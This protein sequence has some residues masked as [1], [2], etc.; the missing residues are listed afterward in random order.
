MKSLPSKDIKWKYILIFFLSVTVFACVVMCG[1]DIAEAESEGEESILEE[2]RAN[3]DSA[4][5]ILDL[6]VFEDF[7]NS[8]DAEQQSL[9]SF[10]DLKEFI[11]DLTDGK[12]DNFFDSF[13]SVILKSL[14][15]YFVGFL[16]ALITILTVS[17]LKS[18]L[19]G[20][21]SP[22]LKTGTNE[23][24]HIVCYGVI[25]VVLASSVGSIVSTT[26]STINNMSAFA[27]GVFPVLLTLLASLGA[28]T[29]VATYQPMMAVLGGGVISIISKVILPAFVACVVFAMVG[30][31][32]KNVKLTKMSKMFKSV[33]S[34]LIGIVFGLYGTFL[35]AGGISGGVM[36][37]V[38]YSAAKFALSSYV[39]ILGGYLSDGFDLISASLLIVK[40][41]FG[42]TAVIVLG[43]VVMFPLLRIVAFIFSVRLC[44][45]ITEPLGDDRVSNMLSSVA[46]NCGLL[47][48]ALAGVSFMFFILIMLIVGV[49]SFV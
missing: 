47:I 21:T 34:W 39:P 26:I 14:G 35:T 11:K 7:L 22:F 46:D 20:M 24:V 42:Y 9:L 29:G 32:S 17:M 12:V 30:N 33:S 45:A 40:N 27:E 6:D 2:L 19:S 31:L 15:K 43:A 1:G 44:S 37:R 23:I 18:M 4:I 16:P 10:S 28:T 48:S 49:V 13:V 8:L 41:A 3:T 25:V 38:G 5:N 36:D